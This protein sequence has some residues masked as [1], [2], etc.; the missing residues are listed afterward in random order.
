MKEEQEAQLQEEKV[1]DDVMDVVNFDE[2]TEAPVYQVKEEA[3]VVESQPSEPIVP[4]AV[5][6][7]VLQQEQEQEEEVEIA[8]EEEDSSVVPASVVEVV[9]AVVEAEEPSPQ[10]GVVLEKTEELNVQVDETEQ[11]LES[12]V[13]LESEEIGQLIDA[14]EEV[15]AKEAE[16]EFS[17]EN[18]SVVEVAPSAAVEEEI[19]EEELELEP[20]EIAVESVSD[21]PI[22]ALSIA[23][24]EEKPVL[25]SVSVELKEAF[26]TFEASSSEMSPHTVVP[27]ATVLIPDP[28][29]V[30]AE[31]H[32]AYLK[33]VI[34]TQTRIRMFLARKTLTK[35]RVTHIQVDTW[36]AMSTFMEAEKLAIEIQKSSTRLQLSTP[37]KPQPPTI[38]KHAATVNNLIARKPLAN[39]HAEDVVLKME[40]KTKTLQK[41][42]MSST[43]KPAKEKEDFTSFMQQKKSQLQ[44]LTSESAKLHKQL[45]DVNKENLE[46]IAKHQQQQGVQTPSKSSHVKS[47]GG[48]QTPSKTPSKLA[49]TST[50]VQTTPSVSS[51]LASTTKIV[52]SVTTKSGIPLKSQLKPPASVSHG[53]F[54]T[55]SV[56]KKI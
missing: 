5:V 21:E 50:P 20:E 40:A 25:E 7:Q 13:V 27:A 49:A 37:S 28:K 54:K 42:V 19:V 32:A 17:Q 47:I 10:V 46:N 8:K 43:L 4:E 38:S 34:K 9:T 29:V 56:L 6:E 12:A 35:L 22:E 52:A 55:T 16:I 44:K 1:A 48:Q 33:K 14:N 24:P 15:L 30:E 36:T 3:P 31:R 41:K 53:F 51:S 2:V 11:P 39:K 26:D 45:E 18:S 23:I